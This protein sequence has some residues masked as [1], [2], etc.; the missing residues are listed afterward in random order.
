MA[1][2]QINFYLVDIQDRVNETE[3][4][5]ITG[6][7]GAWMWRLVGLV[8]DLNAVQI[9]WSTGSGRP[10]LGATDILVYVTTDVDRSVIAANGG[11]VSMAASNTKVLGLT[12]V[13]ATNKTA[14]SEVYWGRAT[15]SKAGV[16]K[17]PGQSELAGAAFHESAHN[18]SLQDNQMHN[19]KDGLLVEAPHYSADPT[20]ANLEFLAKFVLTPVKQ[21][22]VSQNTLKN[23][24]YGVGASPTP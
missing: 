14:L 10:S 22:L 6:R 2:V 1:Q 16:G 15:A 3:R 17:G 9:G 13:D 7:L 24:W 8:P 20:K 11:N 5:T 23:T 19:G 12:A 4:A 18:K 21:I